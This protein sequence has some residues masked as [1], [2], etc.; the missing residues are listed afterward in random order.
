MI[1]EIPIIDF[2]DFDSDNN[3]LRNSVAKKIHEAASKVGFMYVKNINI[4]E[5]VIKEA[6]NSSANFFSLPDKNKREIQYLENTNHGYQSI[7]GQQLDSNIAPDLKET[8]TMRNVPN[9]LN[10]KALWP[11]SQFASDANRMFNSCLEGVFQIMEAIALALNLPKDFF[12]KCHTGENMTL[13]YLHY[14]IIKKDINEEQM[15]AGAHTDFGTV[16]LLFQ[17][18]IG[19]LEVQSSEGKWIPATPIHN[20]IVVNTGDLLSRWT[21][22][23]YK[24][25]LHRVRP[26]VSN[27]ERYSIAFFADPDSATKVSVFP[28]CFN[29]ENP[30][31]FSD[32]TA[33][34]HI[35]Q[36]IEESNNLKI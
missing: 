3:K 21:N 36:K 28:S 13:R 31:K 34:E 10:N 33:G 24:S 27:K 35:A 26:M 4:N 11:S 32:I 7:G 14:P 17:D 25:T 18:D 16:T 30:S 9:N 19:G 23:I 12:T 15:G 8:I 29:S 5:Q 1:R 2:S 22:K 20:T 6:F